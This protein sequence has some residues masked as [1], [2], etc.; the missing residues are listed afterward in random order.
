MEFVRARLLRAIVPKVFDPSTYPANEI[1][2]N[3]V[4]APWY[5][6]QCFANE[7]TAISVIEPTRS[8]PNTLILLIYFQ[9]SSSYSRL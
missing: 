1:V 4:L 9:A 3:G 8:S 5:H 2:W 7:M 6:R